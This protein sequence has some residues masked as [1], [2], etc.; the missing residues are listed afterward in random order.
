MRRVF[1]RNSRANKSIST[2]VTG[3]NKQLRKVPLIMLGGGRE[4]FRGSSFWEVDG[5]ERERGE[6]INGNFEASLS[7]T[8]LQY[9]VTQWN[10]NTNTKPTNLCPVPS[11]VPT[12]L[13]F[14]SDLGFVTLRLSKSGCNFCAHPSFSGQENANL[15]TVSRKPRVTNPSLI[16]M[17]TSCCATPH[18]SLSLSLHWARDGK[19]NSLQFQ[20]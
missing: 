1:A 7:L 2:F 17:L 19:K 15:H 13:P 5:G 9:R 18:L 11:F 10:S 3:N 16:T 8:L 6:G 20:F 14:P 12:W 4:P